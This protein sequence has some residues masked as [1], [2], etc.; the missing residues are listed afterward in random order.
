[1]VAVVAS[2]HTVLFE[3]TFILGIDENTLFG[4]LGK[5]WIKL[6][7][8]FGFVIGVF[9]IAGFN[10]AVCICMHVIYS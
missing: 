7:L 5:D 2:I 3:D 10:Y 4:W 8:I 1:M 6:I 9:C